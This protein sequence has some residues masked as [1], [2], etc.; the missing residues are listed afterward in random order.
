MREIDSAGTVLLSAN[1]N[2]DAVD[3]YILGGMQRQTDL[4]SQER[5]RVFFETCTRTACACSWASWLGYARVEVWAPDKAAVNGITKALV[6]DVMT[7]SVCDP[8]E[9]AIAVDRQRESPTGVVHL[10]VRVQEPVLRALEYKWRARHGVL[11][12]ESMVRGGVGVIPH[13]SCRRWRYV[14][15]GS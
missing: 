14:V 12:V 4:P 9:L 2:A 6:H 8:V 3:N 7:A 5:A 11:A 15:A 10:L 1:M 13:P